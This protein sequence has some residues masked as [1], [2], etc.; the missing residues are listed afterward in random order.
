MTFSQIIFISD[1]IDLEHYNLSPRT[2][3]VGSIEKTINK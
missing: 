1:Y 3:N 2:R